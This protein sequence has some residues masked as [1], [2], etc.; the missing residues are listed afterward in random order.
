M[1]KMFKTVA[2]LAVVMFA[3]CTNDLTNEVV[4]P[5]GETTTVTVGL[6]ETKTYVGELVDGARKVYWSA[7]DQIAINGSTSTAIAISEDNAYADFSFEGVLETPYSILYPAADYVDAATINLPAVQAAAAG[8]F[9]TNCA[10]MAGYSESGEVT[11]HHLAAVVRLQ[12]KLPEESAHKVCELKRI[13]FRGKAGEQVSGNFAIDYTSATLTSTSSAEADKVVWTKVTKTLSTEPTDVFVVVP[14]QEYAEGFTVRLIDEMGHYM[15]ISAKAVTL[16]KGEIKAMPVIDFVP[17][18][19][20]ISVEIKSAADLVQFAKDYNAFKYDGVDPLVV[21]VTEDIVFDDATNAAWEPIGGKFADGRSLYWSGKFEGND[22]KIKNWVSSKPLFGFSYQGSVVKNVIIDASCTL[23]A[24]AEAAVDGV[25]YSPILTYA[26]GEVENCVNNANIT[27]KGEWSGGI[28]IAGITSRAVEGDI[29]NCTNN[30]NITFEADVTIPSKDLFVGGIIARI[31]N[32]AGKA[33]NSTNN[34]AITLAGSNG[35]STGHRIGGVVGYAAGEVSGCVNNGAISGNI[36]AKY[37]YVGGVVGDVAKGTAAANIL[38]NT[39]NGALSYT[40]ETTTAADRVVIGGIAGVVENLASQVEGNTNTA[41]VETAASAKYLYVG[42]GLGWL[43]GA[44]TGSFKNNSVTNTVVVSCTGTGTNTGVGGLVGASNGGAVI[45]L[46]GDKGVIACT[47]KGGS[48]AGNS[49]HAGIGGIVGFLNGSITIKNVTNWTGKLQ[50]DIK[51]K[52]NSSCAAFGAILGYTSGGVVIENCTPAGIF[53]W[54]VKNTKLVGKVSVG[55]MVGL[56]K[57][58]CSIS[59]CTNNQTLDWA[60]SSAQNNGNACYTG[61]IVGWCDA[62]NDLTIT[63]CHNTGYVTGRAY[64]NNNNTGT[65]NYIGGIIAVFGRG[66]TDGTLTIT[67]CSS[68]GK[69]YTTRGSGGGLAGYVRNATITGCTFKNEASVCGFFGGIVAE[70]LDTEIKDCTAVGN[71]TGTKGGSCYNNAGGIVGWLGGTST[72]DNCA[73]YGTITLALPANWTTYYGGIAGYV[74]SESTIKNCKFGGIV[75]GVAIT[76]D[77]CVA[78]VAN[79]N[80]GAG[81][82]EITTPTLTDNT[83]WDGK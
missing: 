45:D 11:L 77:N 65:P 64:N 30:G 10:P 1:K 39:N 58:L 28:Y 63:N 34:G 68:T 17:T 32:N 19:T 8:T 66:T 15:D 52:N 44:I 80:D 60:A 82:P 74:S 16:A 75:N 46:D 70:A 25:Y 12:V 5:V 62:S 3:G 4:A 76:A 50:I 59:N 18:S 36:T 38:N 61:G 47:V 81:T 33:I 51:L 69:V 83:Y 26:K 56:C 31:S 49:N 22:H 24:T 48:S 41:S 2:A 27:V 78:N 55:G 37:H 20:Q 7:N 35:T 40:P 71:L 72:I 57:G 43:P 53:E 13:E 9:A 14:A 29:I 79:L 21:H 73:Y 6:A 23:T 42:G 67:N 54:S